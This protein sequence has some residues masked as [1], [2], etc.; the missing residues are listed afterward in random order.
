MISVHSE[1]L[2]LDCPALRLFPL[3]GQ[4]SAFQLL[5]V[6]RQ[7]VATYLLCCS[8]CK[9]PII[10]LPLVSYIRA[11]SRSSRLCPQI[12]AR[13]WPFPSPPAQAALLCHQGLFTAAPAWLGQRLWPHSGLSRALSAQKQGQSPPQPGQPAQPRTFVSGAC[14]PG[15]LFPTVVSAYFSGRL[16]LPLLSKISKCPPASISL[17]GL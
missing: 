4:S 6:A 1:R 3:E 10:S 11:I 17:S 13:I 2:G 5:C 8:G 9:P 7:S 14:L 15:P 16:A 12:T